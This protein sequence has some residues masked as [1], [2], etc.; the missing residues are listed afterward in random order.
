[1]EGF[2]I[3]LPGEFT[4]A[5]GQMT[6]PCNMRDSSFTTKQIN[7]SPLT[8]YDYRPVHIQLNNTNLFSNNSTIN[9]AN[10]HKTSFL[11]R[12]TSQVDKSRN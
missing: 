7:G 12:A 1:M 9:L 11:N 6:K 3:S 5:S 10:S 2:L 4:G 8:P